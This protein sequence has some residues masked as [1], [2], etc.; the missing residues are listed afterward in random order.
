MSLMLPEYK[1]SPGHKWQVA[2][3]RNDGWNALFVENHDITRS[4]IIMGR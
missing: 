1:E 4:S 2:S 3:G